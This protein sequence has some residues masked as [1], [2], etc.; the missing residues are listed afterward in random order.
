M[1]VEHT[2]VGNGRR[3]LPGTWC[4]SKAKSVKRGAKTAKKLVAE[5]RA[6]YEGENRVEAL[7]GAPSTVSVEEGKER[8]RSWAKIKWFNA[9]P[10]DNWKKGPGAKRGGHREILDNGKKGANGN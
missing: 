1:R 4:H 5:K 7:S 3:K 2:E 9:A 10:G 6:H 8:G